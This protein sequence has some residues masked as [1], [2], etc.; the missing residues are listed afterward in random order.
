[1]QVMGRSPSTSDFNRLKRGGPKNGFQMETI[2]WTFS[3]VPPH[4]A[5]SDLLISTDVANPTFFEGGAPS[6]W[7]RHVVE[8]YARKIFLTIL[9]TP[10]RRQAATYPSPSLGSLSAS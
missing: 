3:R 6:T 5:P 2:A 8:R 7:H 10:Q 4:S 1:M 9:L